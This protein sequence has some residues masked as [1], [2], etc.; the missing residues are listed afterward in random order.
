[1]RTLL[2]FITSLL[3]LAC[4][5]SGTSNTK[6]DPQSNSVFLLDSE[7]QNQNGET[8]QL[9]HLKGQNT[10][11]AMIF[12]SCTT[13]CPILIADMKK[14]YNGIDAKHQKSTSMVLISIDPETDTPEVLK[15]FAKTQKMDQE[16]WQFLT[17][18]KESI[19]NLANVL[20]V[21]YKEISPMEFS[22]SNIISVF[23]ENGVLVSQVE[24][25]VQHEK[26]ISAVNAL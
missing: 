26:V 25:T 13:A 23:D 14:I 11:V 8:F 1:M 15:E 4:Q 20:A 12:T 17:S 3:L 5:D 9:E 16:P 10:V 2:L 18:D 6:I 7:W 22:H 19:R 21:K 24:G